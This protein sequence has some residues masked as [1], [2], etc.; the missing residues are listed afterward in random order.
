MQSLFP[1]A[2]L[3]PLTPLVRTEQVTEGD[4]PACLVAFNQPYSISTLR[5]DTT[6]YINHGSTVRGQRCIFHSFEVCGGPES[7][8]IDLVLLV[9]GQSQEKYVNI[10]S[11]EQQ[12][13]GYSN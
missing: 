1:V 6:S 7:S 4:H 8:K 9:R 2:P 12:E 5:Y 10:A 3:T 13:F 11:V